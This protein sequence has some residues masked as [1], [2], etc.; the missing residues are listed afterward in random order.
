MYGYLFLAL[1][2]VLFVIVRLRDNK[3]PTRKPVRID[4][5]FCDKFSNNCAKCGSQNGIRVKMPTR[6]LFGLHRMK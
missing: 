5:V 4:A 1:F 2:V 6:E 3:K